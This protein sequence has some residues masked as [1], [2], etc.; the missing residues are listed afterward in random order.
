[1]TSLRV[2]SA[3]HHPPVGDTRRFSLASAFAAA[4][5]EA[6]ARW[7]GEFLASRGSDNAVLAA[8]LAQDN[9]W[10]LG[11]VLVPI[12]ELVRL[13]GPEDDV[14]CPIEPR[15]WEGDVD[16]MEDSLD[17]GWQPPPLL[18]EHRDGA[19]LLQD[20]NHRYEALVRAGE[21]HAWTLI[22]FDDPRER[23]QFRRTTTFALTR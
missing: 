8:A 11:P 23:E 5:D 14:L 18:A 6:L 12:D 13:A 10:W 15:E 17:E 20:G 7:V 21:T 3:G 22:W 9:H 16:A 1:M 4:D 19:L 2:G